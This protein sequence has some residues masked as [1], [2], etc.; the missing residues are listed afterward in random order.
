MSDI[1]LTVTNAGSSAVSV[2]DGSKIST[3]VGNGGSVT[4]TTGTISPGNATVVSGTLTIGKVTTLAA[5]AQATAV[6]SGTAYAAVIDLGLPQGAAGATGAAGKDGITPAFSIGTVTTGAAGSS[7][8]VKATTTDGGAKVALDFTIPKGDK[9]DAGSGS[10]VTLSNSAPSALGTAAAGT[11]VEASRAD[12]VHALPTAK[13]LGLAAVATSGSYA[14]LTG[15]PSAYSL[16]TAS[17]STLG[18]IKVGANLTITDGVLAATG[19]SN[20]SLTSVTP[21][22]L[23]VAYVGDDTDAARADHVHAMPTASDVGALTADSIVDGGD[24]IGVDAGASITIATQPSN[25]SVSVGAVVS[26]TSSLP[27]GTWNRQFSYI[28]SQYFAVAADVSGGDYYATS[29]DGLSWTKRYGLARPG[30][31]SPAI[32][33]GG[34]YVISNGVY[35][36]V[37]TDGLAWT[38][39]QL[40][41][42][43]HTANGKFFRYADNSTATTNG[44]NAA[45]LFSSDDMSTWDS[46]QNLSVSFEA[47]TS[48][49]GGG[50]LSTQL[51]YKPTNVSEMVYF[52][53]R[54]I[55]FSSRN[56]AAAT[57]SSGQNYFR[58][59]AWIWTS[60]DALS[61]SAV[62]NI[63]GDSAFWNNGWAR[64]S[65]GSGTFAFYRPRVVNNELWVSAGTTS[66]NPNF[67]V[68]S[69]AQAWALRSIPR[70][71]AY[72]FSPPQVAYG[73]S[74]YVVAWG[75]TIFS[76]ANG[77]TWT[78]RTPPT[79]IGSAYDTGVEVNFIDGY[80]WIVNGG[81]A[82][83]RSANG[84]DW[85]YV[86]GLSQ[87]AAANRLAVGSSLISGN[88]GVTTSAIKITF[89]ASTAIATFSV[90]ASF[91]SPLSYQWQVST[92]AG[93]T[94]SNIS[95]A[96]AA[97][98][99][100]TGLTS[101]D[102]GKRYRCV[103]SAT[104]ASSVT[105]NSA[106]LTVT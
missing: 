44:W 39:S 76:S 91:T 16:P 75:N 15:T 84:A 97:S 1:N 88:Q 73:N 22:P 48:L 96:T 94:W 64:A 18:G 86:E 87:F 98:L 59:G 6:N 66:G 78:Q 12:H 89:S 26:Q 47:G 95:G 92:D 101:A 69:D 90:V 28:N 57:F 20:L 23:G 67:A 49:T 29:S 106:T 30:S 42:V 54:Y 60:A 21:Q 53:N 46:G 33:G 37:S 41:G 74:V 55:A 34:K 104:G 105:S 58:G 13:A 80:F 36:Q 11:S 45:K 68:T 35:A 71:G 38:E 43:I 81:T 5:G 56:G 4:V 70:S 93:S 17:A 3:T 10:G 27:S 7:A 14:D 83:L 99:V 62:T 25:Q 8:T 63:A 51:N 77:T 52:A 9:G 102:S 40:A 100:L 103:V 24:Y 2:A 65:S 79:A 72:S 32:Y 50:T 82:A 31:W 19:G 61:W 85:T